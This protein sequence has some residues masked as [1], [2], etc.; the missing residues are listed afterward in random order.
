ME[1]QKLVHR[2]AD[3]NEKIIF[4]TRWTLAPLY[5]GLLAGLCIYCLKFMELLYGMI[6]HVGGAETEQVMLDLLGLVDITMVAN[7]VYMV[8][9]GG[10]S[11]FIRE[12]HFHKMADKPRFLNNINSGT[13]KIKLSMS[14]VG[15]S[16]VHLLKDFMNADHLGWDVVG[17]RLAVHGIFVISSIGLALTDRML[18]PESHS[19][20][21]SEPEKEKESK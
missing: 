20:P 11:I 12:I 16:G 7:L 14:L 4:E 9:I 6:V 15:V 19:E 5:L 17:K 2:L 18:H 21:H 13:L 1:K 8:M 3:L 10:Y